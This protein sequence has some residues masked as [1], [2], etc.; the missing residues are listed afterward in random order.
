MAQTR[1]LRIGIVVAFALGVAASCSK[2]GRGSKNPDACMRAC[3][4]EECDYHASSVGD[5]D[6][7][8]ECLE[9]CQEKCS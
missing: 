2:N 7:Y 3:D 4:Q 6:A 9:G 8:L 5:N 1:A